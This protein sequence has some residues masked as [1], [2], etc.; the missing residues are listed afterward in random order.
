MEAS[1]TR[2]H[3]EADLLGASDDRPVEDLELH[4]SA[5]QEV[6][7]ERR[8]ASSAGPVAKGDVLLDEVSGE[9]NP[10]DRASARCLREG[11][12]LRTPPGSARPGE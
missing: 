5:A 1:T 2:G 3:R 7:V 9:L 4:P 12:P 6:M 11:H 10:S 8:V